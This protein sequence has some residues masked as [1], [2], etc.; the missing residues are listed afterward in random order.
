MFGALLAP[1]ALSL[2]TTTFTDPAVRS[3]T[4]AF[5]WAAVV[6]AAG[7][8]IAGLLLRPGAPRGAAVAPVAH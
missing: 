2:L 7:A 3:Y 4:T 6:F 8:V 1:A 5:T